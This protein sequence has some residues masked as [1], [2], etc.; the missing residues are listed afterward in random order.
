MSSWGDDEHGAEAFFSSTR[1]LR[2]CDGLRFKN[3]SQVRRPR[4]RPPDDDTSAKWR[5]VHKA[6][7]SPVCER[8]RR[9]L[10]GGTPRVASRVT[11]GHASNLSK[12]HSRD[13][14]VDNPRSSLHSERAHLAASEKRR[15]ANRRFFFGGAFPRPTS[16]RADS[17][18]RVCPFARAATARSS[19]VRS[20]SSRREV[21]PERRKTPEKRTSARSSNRITCSPRANKPRRRDAPRVT[22]RRVGS[23]DTR[24]LGAGPWRAGN[25]SSGS[26]CLA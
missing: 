13:L 24:L 20:A 8:R 18:F 4:S 10:P 19:D 7:F 9:L 6:L 2:A 5:L 22:R 21:T 12:V 14:A 16:R 1:T 15:V 25:S 23:A 3:F 11:H 17:P 26:P